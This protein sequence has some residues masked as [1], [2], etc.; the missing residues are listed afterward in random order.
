MAFLSR[1]SRVGVPKSRNFVLPQL[2]S[3]ITFRENLRL[4]CRLKQSCKSRRDLSNGM[5]HVFCSQVFRVDSWRLV[6][7]SQNWRTPESSTPGP[8]F[9][10]N[11]CF[12][13]PNEQCEPILDIYTSRAFHWYKERNNPLSF[14]L[15]K[16]S[17]KFRESFWDSTLTNSQH[18][19]SLGSVRVHSFTLFALPGACDMTFGST[20]RPA[21]LQP[22]CLGREPRLGLRQGSS[23]LSHL[24][25]RGGLEGPLFALAHY[26]TLLKP[27][28]RAPNYVFPSLGND[29]HIMGLKC[30]LWNPLR[31]FPGIDILQGCNLIIY[32]LRILGVS[33]GFLDFFKHFLDEVLS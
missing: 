29:I 11:L 19:S 21:H 4:S 31:I 3:L 28:T 30:K 24:Q 15:S 18:G 6:V 22:P 25:A 17:L 2:W 32:G 20:Y 8:S 26:Q 14:D 13:C 12:R 10:H 33:K 5:S 27:I 16:R 7:G 9:S 1:D 23:L